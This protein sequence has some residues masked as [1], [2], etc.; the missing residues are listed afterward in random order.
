MKKILPKIMLC[1]VSKEEDKEELLTKLIEKN[2]CLQTIEG[3]K[4]KMKLLFEKP[5]AGG[6]FITS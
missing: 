5:A 1:N 6:T 2:E 4:E 3:V